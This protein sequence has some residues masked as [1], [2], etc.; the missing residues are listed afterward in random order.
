MM[1]NIQAS[2]E[3]IRNYL[4]LEESP[5]SV[6]FKVLEQRDGGDYERYLI[7]IDGDEG[8]R[9]PAYLL[10]PHGSG[11]FPAVQIHHQHAG[12]RHLGKSEVCG[13]AGD[14]WQAFGPALARRGIVVLAADS[15]CFEDRRRNHKGIEPDLPADEQQ[16]YNEMSYRLVRGDTL[17]RKVL[18]DAQRGFAFLWQDESVDRNRIGILGHSYGGNTVLFQS[19]LDERVKFTCSSGAV[20]SY[21]TKMERG[22]GLEMALVIPGF[23]KRYDLDE[24][25]RCVA[26][27]RLL[28]VSA[29]EDKF[30]LDA[31]WV[32]KHGRDAYD[33]AGKSHHLEHRRYKGGHE[34]NRER[35]ADI[36]GWVVEQCSG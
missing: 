15:L 30:S 8:D 35:F 7:Q 14:P 6:G 27:R 18:D 32:V 36:V 24:L 26:P 9:I 10:K 17:M 29:T 19:A 5:A 34:L 4:R 31:D 11:P 21:R 28:V 33:R 1:I 23:A 3:E 13:L 12:Q 20:C 25:I 16:H 22:I 2:R